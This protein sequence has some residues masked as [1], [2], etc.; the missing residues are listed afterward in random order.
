MLYLC[1]NTCARCLW[2]LGN[3][4][5]SPVLLPH[6][7]EIDLDY[8]AGEKSLCQLSPRTALLF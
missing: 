8:K 2:R 1:G 3:L 7:P 4:Q 6:G 5:E